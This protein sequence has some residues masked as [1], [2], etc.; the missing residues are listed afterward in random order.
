MARIDMRSS[1]FLDAMEACQYLLEALQPEID[2]ELQ[3]EQNEQLLI[4]AECMRREGIDFPD[5]DPVRGLTIGSMRHPDGDL[6]IDPFSPEF[7]AASRA[8]STEL[9]LA[10]PDASGAP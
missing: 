3:A 2:P 8:C 5:P 9:G 10:A 1:E 7:R 6:A 4:F